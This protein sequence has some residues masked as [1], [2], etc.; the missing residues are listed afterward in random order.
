M[1]RQDDLNDRLYRLERLVNRYPYGSA[2]RRHGFLDSEHE[3]EA[4]F[5]E[6]MKGDDTAVEEPSIDLSNM[7]VTTP[8]NRYECELRTADLPRY[9]KE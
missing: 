6:G 5:N 2:H 9:N 8:S 7:P 1:R 4:R 3:A